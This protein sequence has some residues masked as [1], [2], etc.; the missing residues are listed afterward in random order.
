V[1]AIATLGADGKEGKLVRLGRSRG[2]LDPPVVAGAGPSV[3]TVLVEPNAAGRSLKIARVTGGAVT[4]GPELSEG[5][6]ESLAVDIAASGGRAAVVWDDLSGVGTE[7]R[8]VVMI[9]TFDV[10][11]LRTL[12]PARPLSVKSADAS[13]PRLAARPGGY[14][15]G[16]LVHG[17]VD[18]GKKKPT[19]DDDDETQG[20]AI[21]PTWIEVVPLDEGGNPTGAARAVTPKRGHVLSFDL[22]PGENGS[23]LAAFRDDDTPTGSSGGKVSDAL[24]KLGGIGDPRVLV[25]AAGS[26]GAPVLLP[27]WISLASVNGATRIAALTPGGELVDDLAPDPALGTGEPIAARGDAILWARPLGKA[28]RL[29]VVRCQPRA[30]PDRDGGSQP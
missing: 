26:A 14:W 6:D 24:I 7:A 5:R 18:V 17:E 21:T 13:T 1:A 12:S 9:A 22:T 28:M 8:S 2:D 23:V 19:D 20:E 29:A 10:A 4:W 11:T 3:L 16:Y 25:E 30:A 27:G 15:L